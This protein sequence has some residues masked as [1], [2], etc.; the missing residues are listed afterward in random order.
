MI[1]KSKFDLILKEISLIETKIIEIK[2]DEQFDEAKGFDSRLHDIK[3]MA[4]EIKYD[5]D[6]KDELDEQSLEVIEKLLELNFDIDYFILKSSNIRME[7][8]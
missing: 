2:I 8:N 3:N 1:N 6:S 5:Q 4:M 7:C